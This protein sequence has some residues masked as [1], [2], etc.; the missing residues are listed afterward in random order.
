MANAKH[1]GKED[2]F[3]AFKVGDWLKKTRQEINALVAGEVRSFLN[4]IEV[5]EII[6]K[7]L[8]GQ[9]IEIKAQI[10]FAKKK[11]PT[12]AASSLAKSKLSL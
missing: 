6:K 11:R 2:S 8:A 3:N 12:K 1:D 4:S 10:K 9:V 7:V 5:D